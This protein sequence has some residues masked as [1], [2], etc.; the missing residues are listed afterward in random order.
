MARIRT[1]KPEFWTDEKIVE[2]SIPARL[3]FVG[4]FNFADDKG[5]MERSPKRIKMQV[6]P[7]DTIDCE[8]L[9]MELITHGLL[10]EYSVNGSQYLQI[11]GF[12]K[13]QKINRP[14]NSNIP[15]PPVPAAKEQQNN[16]NSLNEH[17]SHGDESHRTHGALSESSLNTQGALTDGKEGKG[18]ERNK[19]RERE[20]S[21]GED[22]S[23]NGENTPPEFISLPPMG[24]FPIANDWTPQ[25]DFAR[26]ATLWGKYLG[27]EPGYT[28]EELQQ[29]RD[30]W[31]CDGRVKHHQQWEMAFADSLL[32]S[33]GRIQRAA[34]APARDVNR[35]PEPDNTIPPGFRG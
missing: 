21:A 6:F 34:S 16:G 19:T 14:S 18:R 22:F 23:S 3:L 9:I 33:R 27:E 31:L 17:G 24:K 26:R 28:P 4:L 8:P 11:P 20:N 15:L 7:A 13:H 29:F 2:C 5:C 25:P 32:Q 1:V 35:I 12:L 30:Y 10:T